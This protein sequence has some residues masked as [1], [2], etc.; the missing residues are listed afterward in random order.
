MFTN[1]ESFWDFVRQHQTDDPI[2]LLLQQSKYPNVDMRL[3][4]Q[5]IEGKRQALAKWPT[6]AS[7]EKV[8]Y[9]PKLNREQSSSEYAARY[10]AETFVLPN[11]HIADLTGGMGIDSMAFAKVANS[12]DYFEVDESL[13]RNTQ[14]NCGIMNLANVTCH[15]TNSMEWLQHSDPHFDLIFIDPARR[16]PQGKKV[17]AFE[18]CTPNLLDNLDLI[19]AHT[20]RLLV[21]A[22]PMIDLTLGTQQLN[23]VKDVHL[24][25][26]DGECKEVLFFCESTPTSETT[27]HCIDHHP[28]TGHTNTFHFTRQEESEAT[29]TYCQQAHKYLYEPNATLMK[30]A[31]F[32][33]ISQR[34]NLDQL[35][36]NTHLYTNDVLVEHF[37]G[38]TFI[39][40]EEIQL[41]KKSVAKA[42]PDKKVHVISRNY[43]VNATE[44]QK[45]LGLQE[46][47][48][49]FLIATTIGNRKTGLVC[50]K[51]TNDN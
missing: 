36:R 11:W 8:L 39:I 34:H 9:P 14:H 15:N 19:Y 46:G 50:S 1:L 42:F 45:Q 35:A 13:C 49:D 6:L 23:H 38:R 21:K 2:K 51:I 10:K 41:N 31:P 37:P 18:D 47:G 3:V 17:S 12:V 7:Y 30:G 20:D 4:A 29:A 44:L 27:I 32:A 22:S 33:L 25:A 28:K 5:Q 43:P 40:L 26:I 16:N 48:S 24:L